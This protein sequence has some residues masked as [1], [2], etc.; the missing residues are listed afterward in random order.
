MLPALTTS[1]R[2]MPA[3][4]IALGAASAL[5]TLGALGA[6]IGGAAASPAPASLAQSLAP[7]T[8][9]MSLPAAW[10]AAPV[11]RV[12]TGDLIDVLA[13]RQGDRAYA[14]PVAYAARVMAMDEHGIVLEL[15]EEGASA[16][17][18]ARGG[19]LLLVP[20]LRSTR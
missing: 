7:S 11:P 12:R 18:I 14:V 15:D 1:R 4:R 8:W 19:G 17:A 20:L 6:Q 5:L 9:A 2:R 10:L 13:V 16:I 3:R